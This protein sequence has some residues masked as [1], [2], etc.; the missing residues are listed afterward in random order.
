MR[1]IDNIEKLYGMVQELLVEAIC[2]NC[3]NILISTMPQ[4]E[5]I[6][7]FG[8][9]ACADVEQSM[10]MEMNTQIICSD[11]NIRKETMKGL[12]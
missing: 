1:K 5:M 6:L 4:A 12:I 11:V 10:L 9:S 8:C 2:P 7:I 3:E